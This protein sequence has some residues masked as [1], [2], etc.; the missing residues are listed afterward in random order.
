MFVDIFI[1]NLLNFLERVR[2]DDVTLEEEEDWPQF[3]KS[4][5]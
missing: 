3:E 5:A 2:T 4:Q 1:L